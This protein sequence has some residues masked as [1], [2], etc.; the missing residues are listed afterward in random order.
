MLLTKEIRLNPHLVDHF[1]PK[2]GACVSRKRKRKMKIQTGTCELLRL[3][4][5]K[6][7]RE[8][9]GEKVSDFYYNL[10]M[11]SQALCYCLS[12]RSLVSE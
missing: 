11:R 3:L 8:E 9:I 2:C 7:G 1:P 12:K 4:C 10:G 6:R 5:L